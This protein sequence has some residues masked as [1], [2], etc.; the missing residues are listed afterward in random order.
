MHRR[1]SQH[2]DQRFIHEWGGQVSALTDLFSHIVR[3][4]QKNYHIMVPAHSTNMRNALDKLELFCHQGFMGMIRIH[5]FE[6]VALKVKKA[7][8]AE[9]Y[10]QFVLEKNNG[11]VI[12]GC[13]TDLYTLDHETDLVKILF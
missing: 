3:T 2:C 7:F 8:R 4:E 1:A 11:Q 13:G 6:A 5:N 12:F 10:D 9:G